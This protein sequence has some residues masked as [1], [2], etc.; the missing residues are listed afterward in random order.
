M[1]SKSSNKKSRSTKRYRYTAAEVAKVNNVSESMVNQLRAGLI[2]AT[3]PK[4]QMVIASDYLLNESADK[5]L[6]EVD[7]TINQA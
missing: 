3:T 2:D 4:S 1:L 6:N 5:V 7:K